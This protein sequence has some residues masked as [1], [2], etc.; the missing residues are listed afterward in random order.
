VTGWKEEEYGVAFWP[1]VTTFYIIKYLMLDS[2]DLNDYKESK[3]YSYF[4]QGWLGKI[5]YHP[6]GTST[7]CFMK[8]DCRPSQRLNDTL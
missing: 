7:I 3:A 1:M 2:G 5:L 6:L 8:T 4:K